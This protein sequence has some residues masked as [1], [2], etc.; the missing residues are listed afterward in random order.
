MKLQKQAHT[1]YKTQYHIVWVTRFRRKILIP[2][3]ESYLRIKLEDVRKFF[4]DWYFE[5]IGVAED[6]VHIQKYIG[7]KAESGRK[8][9]LCQRL[10]LTKKP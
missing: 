5:E 6:H 4:P 9:F 8:D 7:I 3:I 1:V 2:G 10:G